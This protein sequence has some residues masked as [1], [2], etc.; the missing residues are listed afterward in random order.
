[1]AKWGSDDKT[2]LLVNT[3]AASSFPLANMF[4]MAPPT[5][6]MPDDA[7]T[8]SLDQLA[9]ADP[10]VQTTVWMPMDNAN[11]VRRGGRDYT[12]FSEAPAYRAVFSNEVSASRTLGGR[13]LL[14][15]IGEE[16][17]AL[18][19]RVV[20]AV[21]AAAPPATRQV[22]KRVLGIAAGNQEQHGHVAYVSVVVDGVT[23]LH[24]EDLPEGWALNRPCEIRG[25][26]V[27]LRILPL[28]NC[29]EDHVKVAILGFT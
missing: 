21:F 17:R 27:S 13:F 1:M 10:P 16:R 12:V 29:S 8:P 4:Q 23:L 20:K 9:A 25:E 22:P 14:T 28:L 3:I 18:P 11:T 6:N 7:D 24:K 15:L 2:R 5:I 19:H 26:Q